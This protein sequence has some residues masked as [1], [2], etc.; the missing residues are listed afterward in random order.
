MQHCDTLILPGWCVP[1]EPHE[2][3]LANVAVAITDG[4][5]VAITPTEE[6][7]TTFQP[8]ILIERPQHI[9]LPGLI[10][11]HTHAAMTLL[12]GLCDDLPLESWLRQG[13][14]PAEK[15]WASAEM[16][17]D[18][19]ELAI[20]EM[21]R[22]G[23]TCFADQYFFPEIV[24]QTAVE[25]SMRAVVGTPVIDYATTWAD[26]AADCL[27]KGSDL[28][29]DPYADHPLISTCFAPHSTAMLS[30]E[31]FV[32]LRV[33]ADQLDIPV[34]LHL[35]ETMAEIELAVERTGKRPLQR[36]AELGLVNA[37]LLVV[38]GVHMNAAEID[39]LAAAGVSLVHCPKS[40][41]KLGSG[42]A[43]VPAYRAAGVNVAI[44]TDGAAS[45]NV[46]D[47]LDELR[48]AALIARGG[49]GDA[50]AL[51]AAAA[52]RMATLDAAN[53]LGLGEAVG[54]I[55]PGKWADLTCVDLSHC[56]SQPIY[57]P[58]SQLV[59]TARADQVSD[60]WVAGKHQLDC[61]RLTGVDTT[62]LLARSEEWRLR[63]GQGNEQWPG[64]T[65][66]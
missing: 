1:V 47:I 3:V 66:Q 38:H 13:I 24:A 57:D 37:S 8:S 48:F 51:T 58:L 54:S 4:R 53:A 28:V 34:H 22:A 52:L 31:S 16:V 21:M 61:G 2:R 17:R 20:A 40:N 35:H 29:H 12:R 9:L 60:V 14:W 39:S 7:R 65:T 44:G 49:S 42:I 25:R 18:G 64:S 19:T 27:R 26:N 45:N 15:R 5:I 59:Y 46:L 41:L 23:V 56:N 62:D 10:N 55:A 43:P 11:A 30:D 63:I 32:E 33:L 36:L 50:S 6:A